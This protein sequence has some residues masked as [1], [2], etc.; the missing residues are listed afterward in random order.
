MCPRARVLERL[1]CTVPCP[2]LRN[3]SC[4]PPSWTRRQPAP[5]HQDSTGLSR[6]RAAFGYRCGGSPPTA[7]GGCGAASTSQYR[8]PHE[9]KSCRGPVGDPGARRLHNRPPGD[10]SQSDSGLEAA[11]Q[12]VKGF[13]L[14]LWRCRRRR[15]R[16]Q[17]PECWPNG[18]TPQEQHDGKKPDRWRQSRNR[19][20][21]RQ[22]TMS[23]ATFLLV[24][25]DPEA[26]I[27]SQNPLTSEPPWPRGPRR[28][29]PVTR[30]ERPVTKP[31]PTR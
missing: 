22:T 30:A 18:E 12:P 16:V 10:R 19:S 31:G 23:T 14:A 25:P 15:Q 24:T 1:L 5:H 28:P 20:T 3:T 2:H 17:R 6:G 21:G 13:R 9:H 8:R 27:P 7:A 26:R 11:R 4:R 29:A